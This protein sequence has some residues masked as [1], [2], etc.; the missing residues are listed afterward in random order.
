MGVPIGYHTNITA[1]YHVKCYLFGKLR[2]TSLATPIL[3]S[4]LTCAHST[5]SSVFTNVHYHL[6]EA[7]VR[8]EKDLFV[9]IS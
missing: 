1:L 4:L 9:K 3:V 7:I 2:Q 8:K 6:R 5:Q